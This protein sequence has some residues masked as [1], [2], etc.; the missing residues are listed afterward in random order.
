MAKKT[1]KKAVIKKEKAPPEKPERKKSGPPKGSPATG[2]PF[3]PG[4]KLWQM[5]AKDGRDAIIGSKELFLKA[6][7]D[8]FEYTDSRTLDRADWVAGGM[9]VTRKLSP[10]YTVSGF[11]VFI[12]ASRKWWNEFR[13]A[14]E[15]KKDRDFLEAFDY[16]ASI[17]ETN[18]VEGASVGHF[19]ANI[20]SRINGLVDKQETEVTAQIFRI[21]YKKPEDLE[22]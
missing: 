8:Y 17:I 2:V 4:N 1:A 18:Q 20:V 6:A 5:R 22:E 16:V 12:G 7:L 15:A 11:C 13:K 19:N 10:P 14:L 21:G 3:K 9:K